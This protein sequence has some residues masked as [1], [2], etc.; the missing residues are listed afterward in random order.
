MT[1]AG[2]P[3]RAPLPGETPFVRRFSP[4]VQWSQLTILYF[5]HER[6][7]KGGLRRLV[8]VDGCLNRVVDPYA[9]AGAEGGPSVPVGAPAGYEWRVYR[10]YAIDPA[11]VGTAE[12]WSQ[13]MP[14]DAT[15]GEGRRATVFNGQPDPADGSHFTVGYEVDGRRGTIDGWL[16]DDPLARVQLTVRGGP[17]LTYLPER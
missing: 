16:T 13:W 2:P 1:Y 5:V 12:Q 17:A 14:F 9:S 15:L 3:D 7:S 8:V 10:V 11:T 6:R 4:E